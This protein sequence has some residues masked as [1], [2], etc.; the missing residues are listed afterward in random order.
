MFN[1][2]NFYGGLLT[3]EIPYLV[4]ITIGIILVKTELMNHEGLI[5]IAKVCIEVFIP[6]YLFISIT[7][8]T[9]TEQIIT[10]SPV[11][12]SQLIMI[13]IGFLISF[14]FCKLSKADVRTKWTICALVSISEIKHTSQFH[15]NTFCYHLKEGNVILS[16]ES[17]YC[18]YI[19]YNHNS[20]MFFQAFILWYFIYFFIRKDKE[21]NRIITEVGRYVVHA[22]Q[23][24]LIE[25]IDIG[26]E[27]S[28]NENN[29]NNSN[30]NNINNDNTKR[31]N[32]SNDNKVINYSENKKKEIDKQIESRNIK[33]LYDE[34][35]IKNTAKTESTLFVNEN[36]FEN[37][38]KK[39]YLKYLYKKSDAKS[40]WYKA[41]YIMFGPCQ[42]ALFCGFVAGFITPFKT[43]MF[44]KTNAQVMFFDTFYY[45][46]ISHL[47]ISYL[48][49][50]SSTLIY[51]KS[52][53]R[54]RMRIIDHVFI[55]LIRGLIFPFIGVLYGYITYSIN[56]DQRAVAY[57]SFL[58]WFT[59]SSIDIIIITYAKDI[60]TTDV[61]I[62]IALQWIIMF[63]FGTFT[64][65]SAF[66][67]AINL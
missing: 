13:A 57:N 64:S 60:N 29:N 46:G 26:E 37:N 42:I 16:K 7:G 22:N 45:L 61:G 17:K 19:K 54:Y 6:C 20:H 35:H 65:S 58:Q 43:W 9:S 11:I 5:S 44:D 8:S 62:S 51:N 23:K 49:I 21:K 33:V 47:V 3:T 67:G 66:L 27:V 55:L 34:N 12:I 50:G 2:G 18:D 63:V 36:I 14:I 10:N 41:S 24:P 28:I 32:K 48:I 31:V 25:N 52:E 1:Y 53:Y 15:N 39:F 4:I 59:P 30:S 38:I 40:F 56:K